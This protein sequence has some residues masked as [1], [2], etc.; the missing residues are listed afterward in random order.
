T[1]A[2]SRAQPNLQPAR[3]TAAP[4]PPIRI[5]RQLLQLQTRAAHLHLTRAPQTPRT[6]R[7][8]PPGTQA[9]ATNS[10]RLPLLFPCW[11]YLAWDH[12]AAA[13][14]RR[15]NIKPVT[16]EQTFLLQSDLQRPCASGPLAFQETFSLLGRQ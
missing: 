15:V 2:R 7:A 5:R 6:K 12:W 13:C 4:Q 9:L 14:S 11:D 10:R 1:P 8:T 16:H 3:A